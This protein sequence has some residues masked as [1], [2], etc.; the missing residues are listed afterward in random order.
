MWPT[1]RPKN[2]SIPHGSPHMHLADHNT[3]SW[4]ELLLCFS[5]VRHINSTYPAG[6]RFR[7]CFSSLRI[8]ALRGKPEGKRQDNDGIISWS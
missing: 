6:Q 1:H 2:Q 8:C 3:I 4:S 7:L 5:E